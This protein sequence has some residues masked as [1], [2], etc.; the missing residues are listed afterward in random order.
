MEV[1][2][3][4][5]I[6]I[7]KLKN[8]CTGLTCFERKSSSFVTNHKSTQLQL[9]RSI[10]ESLFDTVRLPGKLNAIQSSGSDERSAVVERN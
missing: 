9:N 1:L 10:S 3:K 7:H 5:I 6:V 8:I 2:E 4:I